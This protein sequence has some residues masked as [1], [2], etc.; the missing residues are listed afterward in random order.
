MV[1]NIF[2]MMT[3]YPRDLIEQ[4][5][6]ILGG[7]PVIKGTRFPIARLLALIGMNYVFQDIKREYPYIK[8]TKKE[9]TAILTYYQQRIN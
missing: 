5:P 1:Y 3:T 7:Q 6:R 4:N 9:L 2:A 8:I